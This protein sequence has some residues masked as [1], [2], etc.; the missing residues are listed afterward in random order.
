LEHQSSQS[1]AGGEFKVQLQLE[2]WM[3]GEAAL[4]VNQLAMGSPIV[5]KGFLSQH[6]QGS[7]LTVLR[8]EQ[9]KLMIGD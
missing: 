6:H 3:T 8:A 5:V 7:T 4:R 1:E 2:V 9:Y